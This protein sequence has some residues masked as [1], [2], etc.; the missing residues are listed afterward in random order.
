MDRVEAVSGAELDQ[1]FYTYCGAALIAFAA[2]V[3]FLPRWIYPVFVD[4]YYHMAVIQGFWQAGGVVTHAFWEFAPGGRVHIYPPAVHAV[5]YLFTFLGVSPESFVTFISWAFYPACL[6]TTWLWLRHILNPLAALFTT[7]LLCGP[8]TFFW[9]QSAHTA[10]AAVLVL[11]PLALLALQKGRFLACGALTFAVICSH[12]IG[13]FL[14]PAL[15]LTALFDRKRVLAG[16][17][18]ASVPV[19][20]YSPWLAH[21]WANRVFISKDRLGGQISLLSNHGMNLGV[22]EALAALLGLFWVIKRRG[23]AWALLAVCLGF[24]ALI[25]LGFGGR[26]FTFNVHWP[27]ACL[28]GFGLS[29]VFQALAVRRGLSNPLKIGLLASGVIPL[30]VFPSLDCRPPPPRPPFG[31]PG[32]GVHK[33]PSPWRLGVQPAMLAK[34]FDTRGGIS[35]GPGPAG[36]GGM[37]LIHRPGARGFFRAVEKNVE[38]G[39]VIFVPDPPAASLITGV[40]GRWSSGGILRDVRAQRGPIGP[41]E[42]DFMVRLAPAGRFPP[43]GGP[44]GRMP[45]GPPGLRRGRRPAGFA[46]R[47]PPN[48]ELVFE[49]SFGSLMRNKEK[50]KHVRKPDKAAV[51]ALLLLLIVVAA[52]GAIGLDLFA[53][54]SGRALFLAAAGAA[55]IVALS[56]APLGVKAAGELLNPPEAPPQAPMFGPR[57]P[58]PGSLIR[59]RQRVMQ[60]VEQTLEWGGDPREFWPPENEDLFRRLVESGRVDEAGALLKEALQ[61][62]GLGDEGGAEKR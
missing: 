8:A 32:P 39:D 30:I 40:T 25:P 42:C 43:R 28:G 57:P 45:P 6:L 55:L 47:S 13:L 60:A 10:N 35:P 62:A 22:F 15:V 56:L 20:L 54:P 33:P 61:K 1:K 11:A 7:A 19:L 46:R 44:A 49:N 24:A 12:P 36:P 58:V 59:L 14:P 18:C 26:F 48:F 4:T 37:D 34:F 16:L 9:N 3:S 52:I 53:G 27:L 51:P 23:N 38:P 21:V 29:G 41:E 5:G 50:P 31:V 2:L 17:V